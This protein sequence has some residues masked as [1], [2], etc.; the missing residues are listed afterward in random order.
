VADCAVIGLP[1]E[2]WGEIVH[3][4]VILKTGKITKGDEL[5]AHCQTLIARY[6]SPRAFSFRTEPLPLS[7]AGKVMKLELRKEYG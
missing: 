5:I 3:A 4:V 2:K 7:A 6:K 1:D